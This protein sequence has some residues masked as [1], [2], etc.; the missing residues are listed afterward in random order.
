MTTEI[1][2]I[3]HVDSAKNYMDLFEMST[4]LRTR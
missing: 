3:C 1:T 2:A 4:I